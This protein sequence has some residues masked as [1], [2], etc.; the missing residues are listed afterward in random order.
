MLTQAS[1][2]SWI[3]LLRGRQMASFPRLAALCLLLL[4]AGY[5]LFHHLFPAHAQ[6][7]PV[8]S[9]IFLD[10][11]TP[12]FPLTA[13]LASGPLSYSVTNSAGV[14]VVRGHA[15]NQTSLALPHLADDYYVLHLTGTARNLDI[16]FTVLSPFVQRPDARLGVGVHF[17]G[18]NNPGLAQ[19][20]TSLGATTIR[21]DAPWALIE[22]S[23]GQYSFNNLDS[24]MQTL[25]DY[26]LAPLLIL[27]YSNRFYDHNQTPYDQAG[28]QAF[29]N[30]AR[31]L[32]MHY[33]AQLREVEV[34]NEY[35]GTLSNGPCA[36]KPACYVS[37]LRATYQA[38]KAAR[39]DV[40]VI[41]GA[42][43]MADTHWFKEVFAAGGLAFMDVVSDHPYAPFYLTSPEVQ[44]L[45]DSM[46][47][48]QQ[49]I[50]Q[51]NHG[52]TKPIWITEL[53]WTT[54][55][56]HVSEQVQAHYVVRGTVLSLA[57]GVQKIFWYD[58]L[59]DGTNPSTVQ[60]N[61]G[62]LNRPDAVGLYTP[63][64]A[65]TAYAVLARELAG[66]VFLARESVLPGAFS[67]LFSNNMRVLWSTPLGQRVTLTTNS[68]VTETSMMGQVQTLRPVNGKIVLQLS[69][70]PVYIDG[71]VSDVSW[72]LP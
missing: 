40:T 14:T 49:L 2:N 38:V 18:G 34:Y 9:T 35:N 70:E 37:L 63:K 32:V 56:L 44:G 33:G 53:G 20:I 25:Q 23:P 54:S 30:Y 24:Y 15:S 72:H 3:S 59:N 16:P 7:P 52:H 48:L 71:N 36:R 47:D 69:A 28:I 1:F 8:Q 27:D 4:C 65:Y 62:L 11:S 21:D 19:L 26:Q 13:Q 60:Q 46:Q 57:A 42:A 68:P 51:Y 22:R 6:Y 29:A 58:L 17:T 45:R 43:F 41:G 39:P 66:R 55:T 31:A 10:T 5:E 50:K 12:L 64:P 67:M 61:F